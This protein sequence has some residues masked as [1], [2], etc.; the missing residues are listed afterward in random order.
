MP[1]ARGSRFGAGAPAGSRHQ[2]LFAAG[3]DSGGAA[4]DSGRLRTGRVEKRYLAL[5]QG[6]WN[7]GPREVNQP[8]RR[9]VLRG[10]E[11]VEVV[12]DGNRP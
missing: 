11:L 10:G 5:V 2:R 3:P 12:D 8:L 7:H 6:Y 4:A 1:C 9:N